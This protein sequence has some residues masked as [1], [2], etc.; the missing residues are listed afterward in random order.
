MQIQTPTPSLHTSNF[1]M[2]SYL[3]SQ[4]ESTHMQVKEDWNFSNF[5]TDNDYN[6]LFGT[7][8]DGVFF[9]SEESML[10]A[11]PLSGIDGHE[12]IASGNG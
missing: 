7:A 4:Y 2:D 11:S 9:E 1:T 5:H 10:S 12:M 8:Y 6:A 3:T